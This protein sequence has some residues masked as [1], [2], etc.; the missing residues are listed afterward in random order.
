LGDHVEQAGQLVNEQRV[1]FD[2]T[3]FSAMTREEINQVETLVNEVILSGVAVESREMPIEEAKKL[4]AMA[5]FGEKYGKIVRVVTVPDFSKEFCGGTHIDN[6]AKI[7]L[8]KIVS[9]SSVAAGVRRIECVTGAGVFE[10]LNQ[11]IQKVE[12]TASIFKINNSSELVQK[13]TQLSAESKEKDRIIEMLSSKIAALQIDGLF[14]GAKEVGGVKIIT[15]IFAG[16]EPNALRAMCDKVRDHAPNMVAVLAG[17]HE[18][19]ANIAACVA[20]DALQ[21]GVNA[22]QIVRQV[23]QIAGGNGGG[24]ADSAM[25]GAKDLNKLEEALAAVEKIVANMIK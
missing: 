7:G 11:T 18:G 10:L 2:F 15:G 22:G 8:F 16:T 1:R 14:A 4:G 9:E 19:K 5:L 24:K 3:H 23:A 12:E 6:T 13:A 25:A 17:T 20:K 21:K